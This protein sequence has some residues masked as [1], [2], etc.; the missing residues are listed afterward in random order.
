MIT[1]DSLGGGSLTLHP[2]LVPE[3]VRIIY[4]FLDEKD[5]AS[6]LYLSRRT[7]ATAL[8]IVWEDVDMRLLFCLIPGTEIKKEYPYNTE[9]F[10][11][12]F[13]FPTTRDLTR[14]DIHAP[15]VR[16][17]WTS[18]PYVINFPGEWPSSELDA[19][20]KPLLPN[21]QCLSIDTFGSPEA[22]EVNWIP[23]LLYPDLR[24]LEMFSVKFSGELSGDC[25]WLDQGTCFNLINYTSRICPRIEHL[26]LFPKSIAQSDEI[27]CT[28]LY[29]Q[30]ANLQHLR[31]LTFSGT[32]VHEPLFDSLSQLPHLDTL[33]LCSDDSERK[34]G[35]LCSLV[36]SGDSFS[37][38]RRLQL[39]ELNEFVM[40]QVCKV[41][42]LF[43][44]LVTAMIRFKL[45]YDR[46]IDEIERS[47]IAFASLGRNSPHL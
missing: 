5:R 45:Q 25:P 10:R 28:M 2:L 35:D 42:P 33:C 44:H 22:V 11:Y 38:L 9:Y 13:N 20:T 23:R 40:S 7:Y 18:C 36:A 29:H 17:L 1:L 31:S 15:L 34:G 27:N 24:E 32:L 21:L 19:I 6:L 39:W 41:A 12:V 30:I 16:V 3:L 47:K 46:D 43:R 8:P 14:F 4:D 37:S 26:R